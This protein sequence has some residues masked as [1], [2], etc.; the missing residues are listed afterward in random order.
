MHLNNEV[1]VSSDFQSADKPTDLLLVDPKEKLDYVLDE[2]VYDSR[3]E[4]EAAAKQRE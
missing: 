4:A 1:L 3:A 2:P